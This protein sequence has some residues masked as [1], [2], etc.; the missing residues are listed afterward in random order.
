MP[1]IG[2]I[3]T[4]DSQLQSALK[5]DLENNI[6]QCFQTA[7]NLFELERCLQQNTSPAVL[8]LDLRTSE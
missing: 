5:T 7:S 8:Y 1:P 2:I 6:N 3:Y 4:A